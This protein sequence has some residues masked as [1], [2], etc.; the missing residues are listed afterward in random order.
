M[1]AAFALNVF[2]VTISALLNGFGI[3]LILPNLIGYGIGLL[4]EFYYLG[5]A[6]RFSKMMV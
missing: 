3:E 5:V 6:K 4:I 2:S 1:M